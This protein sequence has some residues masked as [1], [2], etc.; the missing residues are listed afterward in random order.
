VTR[1]GASLALIEREGRWFLQRRE[2]S[3]KVLPGR[4]EFP[5]GKSEPGETALQ[6]LLRELQE[7]VNWQPDQVVKLAS[8]FKLEDG[9]E[10]VFHLFH[11][12]GPTRLGTH[13]A[14]GWFTSVEISVLPIPPLNVVVLPFLG[15]GE[16]VGQPAS[17]E[18]KNLFWEFP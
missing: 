3:A 18:Q 7:E 12:Q 11:C 5:G 8:L 13:L 6:T 17:M 9:V 4:W 1:I 2:P 10:R 16:A 14:W 15:K